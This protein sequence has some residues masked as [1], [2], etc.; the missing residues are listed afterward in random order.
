MHQVDIAIEGFYAAAFSMLTLDIEFQID[1][2]QIVVAGDVAYTTT[3]SHGTRFL[4]ASGETVPE[5]NRE[6]WVFTQKADRW[7]I[8]R[9]CFNKAE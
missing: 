3:T 4:K 1:P 7:L 9:Y 2:T 5:I 8:A 6:L